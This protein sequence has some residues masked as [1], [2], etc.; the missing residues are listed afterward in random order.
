MVVFL[1]QREKIGP[2]KTF[3][4]T[5]SSSAPREPAV[6]AAVASAAQNMRLAD[7]SSSPL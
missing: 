5:K 3:E 2:T 1:S 4:R 7:L 6:S